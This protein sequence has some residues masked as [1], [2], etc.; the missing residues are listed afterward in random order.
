MQATHLIR[1][2]NFATP[3]PSLGQQSP[4][5]RQHYWISYSSVAP[6]S[7]GLAPYVGPINEAW[8]SSGKLGRRTNTEI[9][10]F[11]IP[12]EQDIELKANTM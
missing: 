4:T 8:T 12:K 10:S 2:D 9:Q 1:T 5:E 7:N 6:R 11:F 3:F